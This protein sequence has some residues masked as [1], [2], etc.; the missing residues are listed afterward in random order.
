MVDILHRVGVEVTTPEAVYDALTT[1]DGLAGWWTDD[2]RGSGEVGGVLEFRFPRI[3]T[4]TVGDCWT[5][6]P[7]AIRPYL[8]IRLMGALWTET[9]PFQRSTRLSAACTAL[10]S[11]DRPF[12]NSN[13]STWRSTR[14]TAALPR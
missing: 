4:T 3:G 9:W 5:S 2:T 10:S 7:R 13:T 1:V 6:T 11:A 8:E 12:Q 14:E